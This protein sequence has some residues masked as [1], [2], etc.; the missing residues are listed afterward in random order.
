MIRADTRKPFVH[1]L[2]ASGLWVWDCQRC[3]TRHTR[4]GWDH[5]D[6]YQAAPHPHEKP[7]ALHEQVHARRPPMITRTLHRAH[8]RR[9]Q[10]RALKALEH[11]GANMVARLRHAALLEAASVDDHLLSTFTRIV[12]TKRLTNDDLA[13]LH[14]HGVD[15]EDAMPEHFSHIQKLLRLQAAVRQLAFIAGPGFT[16][17]HLIDEGML[18]HGDLQ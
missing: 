8:Q 13:A 16:T 3:N 1:K 17:D 12:G 18:R 10:R 2:R 11:T 15:I 9:R 4:P 7:V 5:H 14:A 6:A